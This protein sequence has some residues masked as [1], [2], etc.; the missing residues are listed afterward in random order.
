MSID[1]SQSTTNWS[2]RMKLRRGAWTYLVEPLV[3]WLPKACSSL[4]IVALRA[5]GARIGPNC[6]ILPGVRV[7]MPWNLHLHDHVAIGEGA[8]IYNFAPVEIGRMT[9][10]S[11]FTYICTGS[12]DYRKYNMPLIFSPITIGEQVWIAA[13]VFVAPGVTIADGVVVGAMSVVTKSLLDRWSVYAGNPCRRIKT[14]TLTDSV[15]TQHLA[16]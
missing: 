9:V 11:Q 4:R 3:R 5:M 13:G 8:N 10:L 14:R 16:T 6:L 7:L 15:S 12:H 1:L 2:L